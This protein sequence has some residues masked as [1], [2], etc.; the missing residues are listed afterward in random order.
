MTDPLYNWLSERRA[1]VLLHPTSLPGAY[2]VGSMDENAITFLEFL[3]SAGFKYWQIGPLGPTGYGDSPYQCF[4][5]FAGN[6]YLIDV[7]ALSRAGLLT[8]RGGPRP[9]RHR[10]ALPSRQIGGVSAR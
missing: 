4:S 9:H 1:G 10:T 8:I 2:G 5:A 6:P 3:A 7:A